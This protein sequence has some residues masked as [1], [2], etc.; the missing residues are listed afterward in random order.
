MKGGVY[1]TEAGRE[2]VEGL[3]RRALD[4]F[5]GCP[6]E[7]LRVDAAGVGTH[8]LAFG[9]P[10]APPVVA[11][12][13]S[14]SNSAAWLGCA[15]DFAESFRFFCVDIPG[16]PGLSDPVRLDLRSGEPRAWLA[17]V[18]DGLGLRSARFATISL[19]SWYAMNLGLAE[20][21]RVEAL[22]MVTAGGFVPARASF[23]WKVVLLS[24]LGKEKAAERINRLVYRETR[25]PR[26]VLEFQAA[27]T[28]HFNPLLDPLPVFGDA[29]LAAAPFPVQFIGGG[30]DALIDSARTARR[31]AALMPGADARVLPEAGHVILDQ[32]P[33]VKA[34]LAAGSGASPRCT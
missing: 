23:L 20:S 29:E 34:F 12:H 32:F 5:R 17:A 7:R 28:E 4:G 19:G 13:G 21:A 25:V 31:I 30:R 11:I 22:S 14:V 1:K 24:M 8:V 18:L 26:E 3:Y 10:G 2:I 16:E 15:A 33:A 27:A 6:F 9:D